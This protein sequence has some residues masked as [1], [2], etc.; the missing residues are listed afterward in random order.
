[1]L[2]SDLQEGAK[3]DGLQGHDW[4]NGVKVTLE[5]IEASRKGNAGLEILAESNLKAGDEDSIHV[6]VTNA[7]DSNREKFQLAWSGQ[8]GGSQP[9]EIYLPPGQSRSFTAPKIGS[10]KTSAQLQLSG[11]EEPFD[12]QSYYAAPEL[13]RTSIAWFGL[14]SVN[15]PE[16]LR[17][18]VERVF[19]EAPRQ[20]VQVVRPYTNSAF[21]PELLNRAGFAVIAG[22]LAPEETAPLRE[23]LTNGKSAL[24]VLTD[25][26]MAP[27]LAALTG[28]PGDTMDRSKWRLRAARRGGPH[29]SDLRSLRRSAFQ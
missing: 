9:M 6:R 28:F 25:Q 2:I 15:D 19:P 8:S 24:L 23:W 14:E 1:M 20:Q 29:A 3:L 4:P 13:E 12:N 11:D 5:R 22:T 10:T 26:Q 18:Y 27:T 16:K 17:Y 7:R 21:S